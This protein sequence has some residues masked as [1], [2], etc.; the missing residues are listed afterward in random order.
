MPGKFSG[1]LFIYRALRHII[2][3]KNGYFTLAEP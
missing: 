2:K 1:K 3:I